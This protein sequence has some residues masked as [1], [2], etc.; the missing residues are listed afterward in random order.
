MT[1]QFMTGQFM[2][3]QFMTGQ[4]MTGQRMTGRRMTGQRMTGRL[5]TGRL[6]T[7]WRRAAGRPRRAARAAMLAAGAV[8]AG[9]G[10][11]GCGTVPGHA[12]A[13]STPAVPLSAMSS[14][15]LAGATW[16]TVPMGAAAGPDEFWQLFR[17]PR[18]AGRWALATPPDIATNGAIL[19]AGQ[20]GPGASGSGA[21]GSGASGSGAGGSGGSAGGATAGTLTA[22]VRPSL[23]L[24]FS[25]ITTTA[26]E[27]H[28]WATLPPE[29]GLADEADALAAAPDGHLIALSQNHT[30]DVFSGGNR[31]LDHAGQRALPGRGAR[32]PGLRA[33]RA[34]RGRL[35]PVGHTAA[36]RHLR[37]G[38]YGGHLPLH[39]RQLAPGRPGPARAWPAA[40]SRPPG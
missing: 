11:A 5:M 29:S 6:M 9:T 16:A 37:P 12:Q 30:A 15:P 7:G 13:P 36:G 31:R 26:D 38:G 2:T 17:L 20:T 23:D 8:L 35:H 19:V 18:A 21:S 28:S 27:G 24:S 39:R 10:L 25:P 34:H 32:R 22:G 1:G 3:G 33:D 4:R 40:P 14:V